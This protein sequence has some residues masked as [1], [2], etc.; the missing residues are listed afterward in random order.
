MTTPWL[1]PEEQA[2]WRAYL[3]STMLIEGALDRQLQADAGIPVAHYA[4]LVALSEA[5]ERR[6]RMRELADALCAS[7]SRMTHTV[8]GLER[9]G[10]VRRETCPTDGRGQYAILTDSGYAALEA[11][12]PGH[13]GAVR[14]H[15]FDPLT[16][17][18]ADQLGAICETLLGAFDRDQAW[19]WAKRDAPT[20]R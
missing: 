13:V 20:P 11:A 1:S 10:W 8:A 15:L 16:P 14:A 6:L 12:A 5:P 4:V 2:T 9:R 17:E 19:P 3:L 18:Q 7:Q